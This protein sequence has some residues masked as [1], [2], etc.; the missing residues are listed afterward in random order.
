MCAPPKHL[1][2]HV[3]AMKFCNSGS[4]KLPKNAQNP[5]TFY[6]IT[7]KLLVGGRSAGEAN[8]EVGS[9]GQILYG[10]T[11]ISIHPNMVLDFIYIKFIQ[12]LSILFWP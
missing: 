12:F 3:G 2:S 8:K 6:S 4:Y 7:A 5:P 1:L 9:H 10:A 11:Y